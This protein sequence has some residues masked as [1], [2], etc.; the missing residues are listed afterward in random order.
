MSAVTDETRRQAEDLIANIEVG[1]GQ[2][3]T[4][5]PQLGAIVTRMLQDLAAL[6]TL[7]GLIKRG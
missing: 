3:L 2:V 1:A 7:L 5:D 4:R 6:R